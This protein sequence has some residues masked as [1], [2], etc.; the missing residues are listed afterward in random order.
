MDALRPL[1]PEDVPRMVLINEQ[2]LPGTGK[3]TEAEMADLLGLSELAL[4]YDDDNVLNGFVLCL[5]PKTSYGSLNY[6]WFNQHYDEFLYVDR[7]AVAEN[8]RSRRIGT[9]LYNKVIDHAEQ[10]GVPV[11][12][13]V[14]LRPPNP[15]SM[16]FHNRHG[17]EKVGVFE[18][19]MK[20]VTMLI[21]R[22]Q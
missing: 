9:H 1:T 10:L 16:R 12:A 17:F 14:S 20:A 19:A 11:T 13:E 18:Q 2:G 6:A 8:V 3:V 21:R 22:S 5:L 4:G 7:I 15:G